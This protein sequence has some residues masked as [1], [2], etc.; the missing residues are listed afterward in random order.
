MPNYCS[1][2]GLKVEG[3]GVFCVSCGQKVEPLESSLVESKSISVTEDKIAVNH[4]QIQKNWISA[5]LLIPS[6]LAPFRELQVFSAVIAIYIIFKEYE[7]YYINLLLVN[8]KDE[9]NNYLIKQAVIGILQFITLIVAF[10]Y[11]LVENGVI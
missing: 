7:K 6:L 4:E 9:V 2:C 10:Y 1:N 8:N 5:W 11:F 3:S